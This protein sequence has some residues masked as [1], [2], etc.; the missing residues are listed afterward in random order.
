MPN[1][2]TID[3]NAD[4]GE[5]YGPWRMGDD[6]A[7]MPLISSANLAC[8]LHAGDP[9]VMRAAVRCALAHGTAIGAHPGYDDLQGF[10]RRELGL[11]PAAIENRVA[12][13]VGALAAIAALA[14]GRLRHVKAHGALYNRAWD[15]AAAASA[16]VRA[17]CAVD[18]SLILFAPAASR[19]L[20]EAHAAGL[21][22]AVEIFADRAYDEDGRLLAR[23]RAG[24]LITE[25]AVCAGRVLAM[26]TAG[27]LIT[28]GGRHITTAIDSV[29][30]H[31]D[32]PTALAI[33][34]RV[35]DAL[36][37]AGWRM[38]PPARPT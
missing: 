18:A 35:R 32:T 22:V 6:A 28:A 23:D 11:S 36:L 15:D 5:A 16:I 38:A 10:G 27:A 34:Q 4:L 37:A 30:L 1:E 17:V 12:Y 21:K 29:C 33:A 20:D 3:L 31:G 2:R 24:A 9:D 19:L 13:Q 8:G 7:L 25:P 26:L 14:G